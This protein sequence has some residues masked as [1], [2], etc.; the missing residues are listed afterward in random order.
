[1]TRGTPTHEPPEYPDNELPD[2][3]APGARQLLSMFL[4]V[5]AAILVFIVALM[6]A[7][8]FLVIPA[9]D[10]SDPSVQARA[11]ATIGALQ[12][13]EV[14]EKAQQPSTPEVTSTPRPIQAAQST[15]PP[16]RLRRPG[17]LWF[18]LPQAS[19]DDRPL[20]ERRAPGRSRRPPRRVRGQ[21]RQT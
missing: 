14:V 9:M 6:L 11:L 3:P 13:Q 19:T 5:A 20:K 7:L 15:A 21:H 8:K 18:N 17:R 16:R 10:R 2:E 12:T 4:P 1:M